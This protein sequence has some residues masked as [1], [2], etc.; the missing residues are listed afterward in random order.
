MDIIAHRGGSLENIEHSWN[1]FQNS[2]HNKC[3]GIEFDVHFTVDNI[4]VI[5]HDI[6][7]NKIHKCNKIIKFEKYNSIKKYVITL[8]ELLL[9]IDG[10]KTLF[11]EIKDNPNLVQL[12]IF[13]D[14]LKNYQIKHEKQSNI[15]F[16]IMSF[17]YNIIK[18]ISLFFDK[19]YLTFITACIYDIDIC[20]ELLKN[21]Y[22]ENICLSV[23]ALSTIML[24]ILNAKNINIYIYTIN[25]TILLKYIENNL[26]QFNIKGIITDNPSLFL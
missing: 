23:D 11:I 9:F 3:H 22:F 17:N 2:L 8:E 4:P 13:I 26:I 21:N 24:H 25:E 15:L 6:N 18:K 14:I 10:R 16:Y 19:K 20:Y 12:T 1:A 7:L 5:N